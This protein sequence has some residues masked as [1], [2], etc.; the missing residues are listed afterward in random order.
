MLARDAKYIITDVTGQ[1]D[2]A[3]KGVTDKSGQADDKSV[4]DVD[5]IRLETY[6]DELHARTGEDRSS[7]ERFALAA[8]RFMTGVQTAFD[9]PDEPLHRGR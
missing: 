7:G 2:K 4:E 6:R 1:L 5:R 9:I 3:I 8:L